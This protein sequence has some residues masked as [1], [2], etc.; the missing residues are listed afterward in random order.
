MA[1]TTPE[2]MVRTLAKRELRKRMRGLR[3]TTPSASIEER[4][5]AVRASLLSLPAVRNARAVALF[6]PILTRHELDLRPLALALRA[7]D[8]RV[9]YPLLTEE[10]GRM[11]LCFVEDEAQLEERGNGFAEPPESA[12]LARTGELDVVV[13]PALALDA[14]GHRLG[15]G[16]GYYDRALPRH[17]PPAVS[18]GVAFS[19]QL[20]GEIPIATHDV[21]V[22][23]VVTDRGILVPGQLVA[24]SAHVRGFEPR[25]AGV[26]VVRRR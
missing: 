6:W 11:D 9:A 2:E 22:D 4:S 16:A 13:V 24:D 21:A 20:L 8:K 1:E 5:T 26:T 10:P 19:F 23:L 14:R 15:Y 3:M 17:C 18:I 12:P 7:M 25:E